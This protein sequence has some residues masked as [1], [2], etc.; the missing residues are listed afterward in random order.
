MI[1]D[2]GSERHRRRHRRS[3]YPRGRGA[4][5]RDEP[6]GMG[7]APGDACRLGAAA[8]EAGSEGD[9]GHHAGGRHRRHQGRKERVLH[10]RISEQLAD[11]IRAVAEDL[12]VPVSNL[13]RN[14]LEE[15]FSV[16][17][18]VSD[19]V[20]EL[21]EGVIDQA[22]EA[23][24]QLRRARDRR[25]ERR[26]AQEGAPSEASEPPG[27]GGPSPDVVPPEPPRAA[28]PDP[29]RSDRPARRFPEVLAWQPVVLNAPGRC[30]FTGRALAPGEEAYMGLTA[31][32]PS[33]RFLSREGLDALR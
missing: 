33:G 31:T 5:A 12:R 23:T 8:E 14:V 26:G 3:R 9:R 18:Q 17:E 16:A 10:T 7:R 4:A 19:D 25:R 30:A 28:G 13:V 21:L 11:D 15:A 27:A 20:G 24:R 2:S 1:D 6:E 29:S 32:G 22:E